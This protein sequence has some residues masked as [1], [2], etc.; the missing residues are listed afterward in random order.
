MLRL[1]ADGR[2][3]ETAPGLTLRLGATAFGNGSAL[4]ALVEQ[5]FGVDVEFGYSS[6]VLDFEIVRL[7]AGASAQVVIPLAHPVSVGATYRQYVN[8][9]WQDF[10]TDLVDN[11]ASAPGVSGACP[12][13]SNSAYQPGMAA[14]DGCLQLTL[15]DGGPNDID[16]IADG[17]IR[18]IG[19]LAAP[20]AVNVEDLPQTS[21]VVVD[22]GEA[23]M[24]RLRLHSDS[25]DALFNSLTLEASGDADD[26]MIDNVFLVHDANRDGEWDDDEA[27]LANGQ[28]TVDNG[29]LTLSLTEPLQLPAGNTDLLV[30]YVFGIE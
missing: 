22:S 3:L 5:D 19:G 10:I 27:I 16:G 30:V 9:Q 17:V 15:T 2:L 21:T 25:G 8:G 12:P 7:D 29:T 6:D 26:L 24:V 4:A 1:A 18:T 28:F 20:V 13:P 23:V 11:I 14:S